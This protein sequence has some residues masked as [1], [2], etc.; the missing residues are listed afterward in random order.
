MG[1]LENVSLRQIW[2]ES[3]GDKAYAVKQWASQLQRPPTAE[4]RLVPGGSWRPNS[5]PPRPELYLSAVCLLCS[6]LSHCPRQSA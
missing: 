4:W 3:K 5:E 1:F 2:G 6:P